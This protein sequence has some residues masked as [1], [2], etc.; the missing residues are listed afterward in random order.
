MVMEKT[1]NDQTGKPSVSKAGASPVVKGASTPKGK[2]VTLTQERL[3][4][5]LANAS[6]EGGRKWKT[7]ADALETTVTEVNQRLD[8]IQKGIDAEQLTKIGDDPTARAQFN[9]SIAVRDKEKTLKARET[10]LNAGQEQLKSDREDFDR[11]RG[12]FLIP[13]LATKYELDE[14]VLTDLGITD[15]DTLERVAQTLSGKEPPPEGDEPKEGEEGFK[16][17]DTRSSATPTTDL[18]VES[19]QKDSMEKTEQ[20]LAPKPK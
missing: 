6:T 7:K 11:E 4:E 19:I 15:P 3:T 5:M 16:P 20:A 14:K 2:S 9:S 18:T 12:T 8:E 17:H 10:E 1:T 13:K